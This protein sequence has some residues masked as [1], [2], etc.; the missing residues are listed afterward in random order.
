VTSVQAITAAAKEA[1]LEQELR[2]HYA[3]QAQA[4]GIGEERAREVLGE[5]AEVCAA[6]GWQRSSAYGFALRQLRDEWLD[7]RETGVAA[8]PE[9]GSRDGGP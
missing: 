3:G 7:G 6:N 2:I 9:D 1:E 4:F 5:W 8:D